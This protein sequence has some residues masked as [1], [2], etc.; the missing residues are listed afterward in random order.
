VYEAG[1]DFAETRAMI[2]FFFGPGQHATTSPVRRLLFGGGRILSWPLIG[3]P[4]W[5]KDSGFRLAAGFASVLSAGLAWR[6][7]ATGWPI[8]RRARGSSENSSPSIELPIISADVQARQREGTWL[9]ACCLGVIILVLGLG[10]S[11]VSKI[12]PYLIEQYHIVADPFVIVIAAL[13]LG[14][15][16]NLAGRVGWL[17]WFGRLVCAVALVALTYNNS[18]QWRMGANVSNWSL[19]Q[20]VG[21]RIQT[22]AAGRSVALVGLPHYGSTDA[23][24]LTYP[25]VLDGASPVG[26]DR[27]SVLVTICTTSHAVCGGPAETAWLAT[28]PKASGYLLVDRF[29]AA[30]LTISVY[31]PGSN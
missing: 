16:W 18:G 30:D 5:G 4:V 3:W 28:Q 20:S 13:V 6:L 1:H 31:G 24:A 7:V 14:A 26:P 2:A 10:L 11:D 17:K 27:A 19:A 12:R 25:L 8:L 9:V 21:D 22:D 15:L 23:D 29:A